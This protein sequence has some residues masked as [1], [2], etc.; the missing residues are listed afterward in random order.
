MKSKA[1][2]KSET[3]ASGSRLA[4]LEYSMKHKDRHR[5]KYD[6]GDWTDDSDQMM[7]ILLSLIDNNGQVTNYY[8][9][10][11]LELS[12]NLQQTGPMAVITDHS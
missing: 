8:L 6:F 9:N 7:L 11:V 12:V 10:A 2:M 5:Q 3:I 4:N 1:E